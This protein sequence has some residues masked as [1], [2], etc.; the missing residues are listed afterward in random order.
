MSG[1]RGLNDLYSLGLKANG[2][3]WAWGSDY[4]DELGLKVRHNHSPPTRIA[5][6]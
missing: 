3:F 2:S 6:L 1:L 5:G 4:R